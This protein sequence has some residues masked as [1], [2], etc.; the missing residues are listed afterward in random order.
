MGDS[1]H[2]P[3]R[4]I[5]HGIS[6]H[7]GEHLLYEPP[8][9]LVV[10]FRLDVHAKLDL[11]ILHPATELLAD[12]SQHLADVQVGALQ[13][14]IAAAHPSRRQNLLYQCLHVIG[15]FQAVTQVS[16]AVFVFA[17]LIDHALQLPLDDGDGSFQ[18]MGYGGE[19]F[20]TLLFLLAFPL[21]VLL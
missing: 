9:P 7:I 10:V 5:G 18:F 3:H 2:R 15:G 20:H 14:E 11:L 8:V 13:V 19:E 12:F 21:D 4:R 6:D 16:I 17:Y 1:N